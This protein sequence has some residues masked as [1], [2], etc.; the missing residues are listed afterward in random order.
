M[1]G[2]TGGSGPASRWAA[3]G[4]RH[5]PRGPPLPALGAQAG[6]WAPREQGRR[7]WRTRC[8][9][10]SRC[11]MH[12]CSRR[13]Q[14]VRPW[15]AP[16]AAGGGCAR[17]VSGRER[18]PDAWW[19]HGPARRLGAARRFPACVPAPLHAPREG[20]TLI[21]LSSKSNTGWAKICQEVILQAHCGV[22]ASSHLVQHCTGSARSCLTE[23]L[24]AAP[25][26]HAHSPPPAAAQLHGA[27]S[28][29]RSHAHHDGKVC[30]EQRPLRRICECPGGEARGTAAVTESEQV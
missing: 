1:S 16:A 25:Y 6:S 24:P 18:L 3:P 23:P 11:R 13:Q 10:R 26:S 21:R 19:W 4:R 9:R 28:L 5:L 27:G 12:C 2:R 14:L 15:E 8:R 20:L 29:V 22:A 30:N 17:P 7:R